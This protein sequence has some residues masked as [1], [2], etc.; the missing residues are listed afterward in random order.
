MLALD[1]IDSN[2][3]IETKDL[4]LRKLESP[5]LEDVFEYAKDEDISKYTRF[6]A[7][8]T[9]QDTKIF[10]Q[11][12][13]QKHLNRLALCLAIEIKSLK[14][15]IGTISFQD[16]SETNERTEIGFVLSK[17]FWSKGYMTQSLEKMLELGFKKIK[18]NRIEAF[19]DIENIKS[20]KL[21]K[22]FM[23]FEG[24]LRER[25]KKENRFSSVNV[26]S[27][28]RKDYILKRSFR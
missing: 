12:I 28:L 17:K 7:H 23:Q 16:I 14:K 6:K 25:E 8:K 5:D 21:L 3:K 2:I 13:K 1:I 4:L 11:V 24:I 9:L 19:C 10:F 20:I 26:F 15:V 18:F 27:I 22:S